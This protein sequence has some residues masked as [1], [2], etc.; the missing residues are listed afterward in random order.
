MS[1]RK[2]MSLKA[3]VP[4]I[5]RSAPARSASRTASTVRRPPPYWI[6]MPV[7]ATIRRRW[8]SDFGSPERAPSRSTTCRKRAPA[9]DP[10]PRGLQRVVVVG[11]RVLEA[12]LDQAHGLAVH[13]VDRRVEDH[14]TATAASCG[15]VAQH[16]QPVARGLLG[17]ELRGHHV[18]ALDDG[19]EALAVLARARRRRRRRPGGRR[20][21][22]RGRRPRPRRGP[23]SAPTRARRSRGSSRCAAAAGSRARSPSRAG[24]P[25][26]RGALVL[27][28]WTRTAAACRGR[29][30][31][32]ARRRRRARSAP[33]RARCARGCASPPGTRR[34]RAG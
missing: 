13:D 26:P 16:A 17:V 2:S 1:S 21:S 31:A 27:G 12:A 33:R 14:A 11:G 22:A 20:R 8:S 29:C 30:R 24:C 19:H 25:R 3:A 32:A 15:E 34:R 5:A 9:V 6:G 7:S 23:R 18:A 28:R 4:T 10:G